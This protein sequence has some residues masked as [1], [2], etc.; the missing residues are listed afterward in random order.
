MKKSLTLSIPQP[1]GEDWNSFTPTDTG[2]FCS[3][4][5]KNVIDFTHTSE[6]DI[7]DFFRHQAT[8][9]CGRFRTHQ[10]KA[11][12]L[13]AD[14]I[15]PGFMLLRAGLLGLLLLLINK[16]TTAHTPSEKAN[17][18][19]IQHANNN[20]DDSRGQK[21]VRVTGIITSVDD[22]SPLPFVSISIKGTAMSAVT[23][24]EGKFDIRVKQNGILIIS[25]IGYKTIELPVS[26]IDNPAQAS[27]K[28]EFDSV[29]LGDV[30]W[31]GEAASNH[32]YSEKVG[33]FR[34][35]WTKVKN[36]F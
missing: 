30:M 7:Q 24:T 27:I 34:R 1:C 15:K 16:P 11:Y 23:D 12:P 10:L 20:T 35:A 9:V 8:P 18:E 5:N 4:C 31:V 36:V 6:A 32:P 29:M 28:M 21:E 19:I 33:F 22:C 13:I 25:Y 3:S 17:V 14:P 2:G 26:S